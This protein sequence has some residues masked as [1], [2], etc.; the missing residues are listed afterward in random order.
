MSKFEK[1]LLSEAKTIASP[2]IKKLSTAVRKAVGTKPADKWD[3]PVKFMDDL[4]DA[5][6]AH[7]YEVNDST[8]STIKSRFKNR[9]S[10]VYIDV[11]Q[12]SSGFTFTDKNGREGYANVSWYNDPGKNHDSRYE[13]VYNIG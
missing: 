3:D 9:R 7:G 4:V 1:Y 2:E 12:G 13:M 10:D 11:D 5:I 8:I 6:E